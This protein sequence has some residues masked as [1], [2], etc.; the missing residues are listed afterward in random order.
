MNLNASRSHDDGDHDAFVEG[1]LKAADFADRNRTALI[2]AVVLVVA[3][4]AGLFAWRQAREADK[5]D[6]AILMNRALQHFDAGDLA[7]ARPWLDKVLEGFS[8][9]EAAGE[10]AYLLG[11]IA[12]REGDFAQAETR[13][14][15]TLHAGL[16]N[17]FIPAAAHAGLGQCLEQKQD[18]AA[19]AK[20]Y[21][22]A[23]LSFPDNFNA[24]AHLLAAALC[25]E[26][27]GQP[28]EA[29]PLLE[30]IVDKHEKSS[31]KPRAEQILKRIEFALQ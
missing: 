2:V 14:N 18:F 11:A 3:L 12:L 21:A 19:A 7:S 24:P 31:E 22:T 15:E 17:G 9:T 5:A 20:E 4:A 16:A 10:A 26:R 29:K 1:A 27:A 6:A 23:G 28:A 13:F 8:G 30:Q 25:Y